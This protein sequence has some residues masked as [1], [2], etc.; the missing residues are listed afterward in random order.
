MTVGDK[1]RKK[2][3]MYSDVDVS[4]CSPNNDLQVEDRGLEPLTSC[5]PCKRSIPRN[6]AKQ[7]FPAFLTFH[8]LEEL[9][10]SQSLKGFCCNFCCKSRKVAERRSRSVNWLPSLVRVVLGHLLGEAP[11]G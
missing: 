6:A 1:I 2:V 7:R 5:M 4:K 9:Q 8:S 3:E 10:E 11:L